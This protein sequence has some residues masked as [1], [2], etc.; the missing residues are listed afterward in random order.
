M[1]VSPFAHLDLGPEGH[2]INSVATETLFAKSMRIPH[3]DGAF[4]IPGHRKA[5][6]DNFVSSFPPWEK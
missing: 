2:P 1:A 4:R 3:H 5:T 6:S